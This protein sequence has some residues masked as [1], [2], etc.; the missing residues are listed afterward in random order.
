MERKGIQP[1]ATDIYTC[2]T[3]SF[4]S[5][6]LSLSQAMRDAE[7]QMWAATS[8]AANTSSQ[9][10]GSPSTAQRQNQNSETSDIHRRSVCIYLQCT[11][12][13]FL[14][15]AS[16]NL[17]RLQNPARLTLAQVC[18]SNEEMAREKEREREREG[19]RESMSE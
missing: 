11:L 2:M 1:V 5:L 17:N 13:R 9:P 14:Q 18:E 8:A 12:S 3:V 7:L 4:L 15:V 19:K 16:R 10:T 6:S